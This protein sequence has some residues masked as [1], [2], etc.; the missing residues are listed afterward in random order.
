MR[1][2]EFWDYFER[3][4][5]PNLRFRAETFPKIFHYL[6]RFDRPVGIVETGCLRT[7]GNWAG[8]GQ[9]TLLFNKYAESHPQSV[10]FSVDLDAEAVARC[11]SV[12]GETVRI[13]CGDSVPYLKTLA[14]HPPPE[15]KFIDLL[16]LDSFDVN[17]DDPLP[18]AIHHLKE[19]TAIAPLLRSE[20]LV[21]VDDS[22]PSFIGLVGEDKSIKMLR[23]P[24]IGGKGKLI[25]EYATQIGARTQFTGYQ[26]GWTNLR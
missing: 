14:D 10:V 5:R 16:Y 25:A 19:L 9:S 12:V 22:P 11:R 13:H 17:I 18:S 20:T 3:E 1:S 15:L 4:A 24:R 2:E 6:D 23:P 8:D 7:P 21:A 26:C